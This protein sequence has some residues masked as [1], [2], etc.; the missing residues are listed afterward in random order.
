M[1]LAPEA[2][3]E[4][5][6]SVARALVEG[7]GVV[8]ER[9]AAT[10]FATAR[11][12]LERDGAVVLTGL[13]VAPDSLPLAAAGVLG[14]RLRQLYPVRHRGSPEG[15]VVD[16]HNDSFN[17]VV[18]HGGRTE[19]LRDPDEDHVLIQSAR[20]APEGGESV[21]VDAYQVIDRLRE[22]DA[23]L[24]AFLTGA[25]LDYFGAWATQAGVPATP[26]VCRHVEWT[27]AGRRMVRING[28]AQ[29]LPRDPDAD[30]AH[31]LL[32]RYRATAA[33]AFQAAP[34]TLLEEGEVLVLDNY[35][36]WH[37]RDPH[38][39]DRLVYILTLRTADAR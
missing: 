8:P 34:R 26:F 36:C 24:Y 32:A 13:P 33:A 35:R 9:V 31:E 20:R 17:V 39:G 15:G 2:T 6:P 11:G 19:R 1:P 28:G 7:S 29:P 16:L 30:R 5:A 10:D 21:V 18:D 37:G 25:D 27:R 23:E 22:Y 3:D 14:T 12:L 38:R 4:H